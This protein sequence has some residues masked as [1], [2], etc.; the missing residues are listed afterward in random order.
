MLEGGGG[1][2]S[3]GTVLR[4]NGRLGRQT[5]YYTCVGLAI[6]GVTRPWGAGTDPGRGRV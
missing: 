3:L 5:D 4:G 2:L 1:C 6:M